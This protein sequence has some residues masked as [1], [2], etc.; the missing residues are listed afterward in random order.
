MWCQVARAL[1]QLKGG[2]TSA[3]RETAASLTA[4]VNELQGNRFWS[5]IVNWWTGY[6][7]SGPGSTTNWLDG[8]DVTRARWLA[9]LPPADRGS[10]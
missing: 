4:T 3:S 10:A 9:V 5:E 6:S 8:R 7:S 1:N 2:D